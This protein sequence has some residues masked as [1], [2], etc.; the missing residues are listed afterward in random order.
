MAFK[1]V[2]GISLNYDENTCEL[3]LMCYQTV[4]R[5]NIW[6]KEMFCNST[7]LGLIENYDE[8][9]A[10]LISAVIFTSE[11]VDSPKVF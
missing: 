2:W 1:H 5:F 10:M 9:A 6:L 8:S 7:C 4:L 3:Q 11:N